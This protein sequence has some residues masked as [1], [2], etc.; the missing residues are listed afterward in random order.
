M[1]RDFF[2]VGQFHGRV[3]L[4][5]WGIGPQDRPSPHYI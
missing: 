3:I 1:P 2:A 4:R 5:D